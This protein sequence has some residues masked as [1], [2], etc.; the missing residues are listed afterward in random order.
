MIAKTQLNHFSEYI[1][2]V[3]LTKS[4]LQQLL[5]QAILYLS[6]LSPINIFFSWWLACLKQAL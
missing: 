1:S 5:L 6:T 3:I 4:I 2:K